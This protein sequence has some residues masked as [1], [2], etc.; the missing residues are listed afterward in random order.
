MVNKYGRSITLLCMN[1]C[2]S[3]TVAHS[4]EI[5]MITFPLLLSA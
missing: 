4:Q 5:N 3:I 2:D 1:T